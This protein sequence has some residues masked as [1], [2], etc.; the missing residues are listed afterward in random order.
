M[1]GPQRPNRPKRR[2]AILALA[3]LTC[4]GC[5]T[6]DVSAF[7][8]P[9]NAKSPKWDGIELSTEEKLGV[10]LIVGLAVGGIVYAATR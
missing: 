4:T 7:G 2:L 3:A 1:N 8:Q 9:L 5:Q 6:F 10:A